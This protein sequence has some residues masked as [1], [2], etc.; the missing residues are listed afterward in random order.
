MPRMA[1]I[2]TDLAHST[3]TH[4]LPYPAE[5]GKR[6]GWWE[7]SRTGFRDTY[8]FDTLMEDAVAMIKLHLPQI[9][10]WQARELAFDLQIGTRESR[11]WVQR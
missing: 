6:K 2:K 10:E 11:F 7:R 9:E 1:E 5:G 3:V 8:S 4:K